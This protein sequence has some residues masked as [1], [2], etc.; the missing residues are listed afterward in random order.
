MKR[1]KT[2]LIVLGILY[3]TQLFG[4]CPNL[5]IDLPDTVCLGENLTIVNSSTANAYAW[6][7]CVGDLSLDPVGSDLSSVANVSGSRGITQVYDGSNWFVFI[8]SKNNNRLIRLDLGNSLS[9]NPAAPVNLGNL[10][11]LNNPEPIKFIQEGSTWYGLVHNGGTG[12][13]ILLDFGTNLTSVPTATQILTGVGGTSSNMDLG[14]DNGNIIV[15]VSNFSTN[16]VTQIN[17]GNSLTN[18][19]GGG[20]I[21]TTNS[22]P[23]SSGL[24]DID[25]Q[26]VCGIWYGLAVAL[27]NGRIFRLNFGND[28]FSE[29]AV[30]D[31]TGGLPSGELPHRASFAVEGEMKYAFVAAFSGKLIRLNF[32]DSFDNFPEKDD[33]TNFGIMSNLRSFSIDRGN[34]EW[35]GFALNNSSSALYRISFPNSCTASIPE[36]N[37]AEPAGVN[38]SGSGKHYISLTG[39]DTDGNVNTILDSV[40]VRESATP[41]F[42]A[43]LTCFGENTAFT[44]LSIATETNITDWL[45]DFDDPTTGANNSSALQNPV[46]TFSAVG[47]YN[48][49]LMVTDDCGQTSDVTIEV[50][51]VSELDLQPDFSTPA[52]LCSND[53]LSFTDAS[54]FTDDSPTA[55]SW[56]FGDPSSGDNTSTLQ[57]PEHQYSNPGNYDVELRVTGIS[58]CEKTIIKQITILEGP[59]VDYT[60]TDDCL[61]NSITFTNNS[62]G[63]DITGYSWDFGDGATSNLVNPTHTFGSAGDY[64]IMLTVDNALG[65]SVTNTQTITIHAL[66]EVAFINELACSN[67]STQFFDQ[68]TVADANITAWA[69]DFGDGNTSSEKDPVHTYESDG[70]FLVSLTTTSNFGCVATLEK[71]VDV[72][73]GPT[74][75]FDINQVCLGEAT[76]FEDLSETSDGTAITSWFWEIDGQVFTEQNPETTFSAPG[77][78]TASL[79]VT[80]ATFC[81][82]SITKDVVINP[83]P[84]AD[85]SVENVC[86]GDVVRFSDESIVTGDDIAEYSWDFDGLG[87]SSDANPVFTFENTGNYNI[88][89]TITTVTGCLSTVNKTITVLDSPEAA[90]TTDVSQGPPPLTVNFQNN[91][92]GGDSNDWNFGNGE[93]SSVAHP[94]VTFADLGVFETRLVVSTAAGCRDTVTQTINVVEP[95]MDLALEGMTTLTQDGETQVS[96]DIRNNGTLFV[97]KIQVKLQ[98]GPEATVNQT[99]TQTVAPGQLMVYPLTVSVTNRPTTPYLCATLTPL[100]TPFADHNLANNTFCINLEEKASIIKPFPNPS[101]HLVTVGVILQES[102]KVIIT[103]HNAV[104][105]PVIEKEFPNAPEG[106]NQ[107]QLDVSGVSDGLYWLKLQYGGS[108]DVFRMFVDK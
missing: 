68:T 2:V 7:F 12:S 57:N 75:D 47:N 102:Q 30:E 24:I 79:T 61:N 8:T 18:T 73:V 83:L 37:A 104:G 41:A 20:D 55:W 40:Y 4:Q 101:D 49:N 19:P 108:G 85:F 33:L 32:G 80:S 100:E 45:W 88:G 64:T 53:F 39:I 66:P 26:Q 71:T 77:T 22:F 11:I 6:D 99:I 50:K 38:Y 65:C 14:V 67:G 34:S 16:N 78:Y 97:D 5:S 96:L 59:S 29:P 25:I 48:V 90:F 13:L 52:L 107:F 92:T 105:Q 84:V 27:N 21:R 43:N 44:D 103:M 94:I 60:F 106:L 62:S 3:S 87:S 54:T 17:F 74:V 23:G 98:I 95:L 51:I 69:W 72:I 82:A 63:L 35:V 36:S 91:S 1:I 89:L 28:L 93:T 10:G 70:P 56:N 15:L 31:V 76:R 86:V 58:G 46:H 9:N 42:S 81:T